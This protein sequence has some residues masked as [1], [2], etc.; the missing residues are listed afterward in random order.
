[1]ERHEAELAGVRRRTGDDD[2]LRLEQG[3]ERLIGRPG[4]HRRVRRCRIGEFDQGVHR[5]WRPIGGDDQRIDV[6]TGDVR[7]IDSQATQPHEQCSDRAAV[8]CARRRGTRRAAPA[9]R[10]RRSSRCAVTSSSGA[11]RKTTSATAS[12]RTPPTPSITVGPNW[13]SRS[14]PMINSRF[15][16]TI[17]AT[18]T[19]TSPSRS[20]A[21]ANSSAAADST[22]AASPKSQADESAFGLVGDR[23]ALELGHHRKPDRLGGSDGVGR[24]R[25]EAFVGNR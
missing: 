13:G 8:D 22:A 25:D 14:S 10:G 5:Q 3:P 18:S 12:A 19:W 9:W 4:S 16:A 11:G 24:R 21:A 15:P 7:P 2:A 20:V 6:D 23:V 1:M 17:G